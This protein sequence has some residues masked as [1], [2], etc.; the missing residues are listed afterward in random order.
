MTHDTPEIPA[1]TGSANPSV[2]D[3]IASVPDTP[4]VYLWKDAGGAVL[5]VG[6]AKSLRK[7]MRQY[8]A[9]QDERE[10]I[11]VMME[12][13]ASYDYVVTTN[14]VESLILEKNLIRQFRPP[15]NVDYRDDKS[16]PFIALTLDD[17]YP[18]IKFTREKHKPGTR[19]FG[20]FTDSR[21]ARETIDTVRRIVPICRATC[22]EWK[23]VT[24]KGGAPSGRACFDYHVGL[25]PGPCVG[26]CTTADYADNVAKVARFLTG[27]HDDLEGE[28]GRQ[29]RRA[30]ADLDFEAAARYRNRLEAVQAIRERQKVVS[31][32]P[33]N[34]DVVGFHREETV[35]GVHVFVVREGRV[36]Y[37]NEFVLDK[38]LDVPM[39]ELV[40]GFLLRYYG[41]VSDT[42]RELVLP[43]LPCGPDAVAAWL[44]EQRGTKVTLTVPQRGEKTD[45][46]ALAARN[47]QHTL[48]RFKVRTRYDEERLNSA[49]LQLESALALPAPPLRIEC[50]DI[51]TLHGTH[52]VAS[53]V[54]F[55]NGRADSK[56][57]R[58]FR[59]RLDSGEANDVAMMSEVLRRR[60]APERM[61]DGR[62]GSRP[63]LV[64]VD[65]G[66]PQLNA[67]AAVLAELGLTDI[68]LAGL[69]KR[70]EELFVTWADDPVVLPSG[71]PSL[72][73]V[74]RVRDEAHR[75]AIE[76]HRSLRG[77]A[78]TASVLDDIEGVGP[79]RKKALL[80]HFGSV[81]KLREATCRGDRAG[82]GDSP[83]S[84]RGDRCCAGSGVAAGGA[85]GRGAPCSDSPRRGPAAR[86]THAF[87]VPTPPAELRAAPPARAPSHTLTSRSAEASPGAQPATASRGRRGFGRRSA[88]NRLPSAG[89]RA[90]PAGYLLREWLGRDVGVT[91]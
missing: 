46:L 5:Y 26:A 83:R 88:G 45:L 81:K 13:V 48:M 10:K 71:S 65:G 19:Y 3:Q 15:Y 43:E 49:L 24:A 36:L 57:Y 82:E 54:V 73:L 67:A 38:G 86:R 53:M 27:K 64:I 90:G 72:Y 84:G 34:M 35:A 70:E 31:S 87:V 18:A 4:G 11:P 41:D 51:S 44:T 16:Y 47:A 63:G 77:K 37:G 39:G 69:A 40:E 55:S 42:P 56:N 33:L 29:M 12:Q 52:S 20:P 7:R 21:A 22:A 60:F 59:V 78:M 75:F 6:K 14:E 89:L 8:T 61:A 50:Y 74:K 28:L 68:P 23:R 2:A 17:P 85:P 58:R 1:P 76:Y 32:R 9:G 80:R 25:G 62:F 66:K 30:A 79:T 91:K